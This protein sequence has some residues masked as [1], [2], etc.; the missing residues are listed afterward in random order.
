MTY[1][2]RRQIEINQSIGMALTDEGKKE[3]YIA[4]VILPSSIIRF[5]LPSHLVDQ[6]SLL[7]DSLSLSAAEPS[8]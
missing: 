6:I 2:R 8:L 7:S 5:V 1:K 4:Y 3:P